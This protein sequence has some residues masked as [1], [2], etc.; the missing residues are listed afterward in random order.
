MAQNTTLFFTY[1]DFNGNELVPPLTNA[2][3]MNSLRS[4]QVEITHNSSKPLKTGGYFS[5]KVE[6]VFGIR[7]LN[8]L[9]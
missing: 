8:Y 1:L 9:Y 4:I 7:N 5:T 6:Q 2:D 3:V